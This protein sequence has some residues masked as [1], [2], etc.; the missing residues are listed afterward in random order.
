MLI[1]PAFYRSLCE[2]DGWEGRVPMNF[3][4]VTLMHDKEV[5]GD[6]SKTP[7][8]LTNHRGA[9]VGEHVTKKVS[10][11]DQSQGSRFLAWF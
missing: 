9:G 8:A 10:N 11:T 4:K 5:G 6:T 3:S 7:Q 1:N 2:R